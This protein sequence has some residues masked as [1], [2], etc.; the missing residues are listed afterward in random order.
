MIEILKSA[1]L[2]VIQGLTEFLPVSSSGHLNIMPWLF[3]WENI[4]ESFDLALHAGTLLAILVYYFKDW[5]DLICGG[6]KLVFKGQKSTEG[7]M[8]WY[9]VAATIPAGVIGYLLEKGVEAGVGKNLNLEMLIISLALIIMG[10]ILYFVDKGCK[11]TTKYTDINF[12]QS[13]LIGVSQSL[14][15][16]VPG[17]SR[18]GIT[19][20]VAR[21]MGVDRESAAKYSF[22]LSA[23][24]VAG[25]VLLS[26]GEFEFS[27]AFVVGILSSFISGIL[28]IKFLM[29]FLSKGSFKVFAIYRVIFGGIILI[30]S[31]IRMI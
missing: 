18:S 16:A 22:M 20:T 27:L 15:A 28:V 17:V 30:L 7:K 19:M 8:F 21:G 3:G 31:I 29:K 5:I 6:C 13:F 24:I 14:A 1:F 26:L 4:P 23:P 9:I 11:A 2:G 10:I 25:G 12:K